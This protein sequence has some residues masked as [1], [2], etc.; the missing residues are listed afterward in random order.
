MR[1]KEFYSKVKDNN[2]EVVVFIRYGNFYRCYYNDAYIVS[3][4]FDYKLSEK[5]STG[6]PIKSIDKV[7]SILRNN[8]IS[9]IVIND[10]NNVINYICINNKYNSFLDLS[11]KN[12]TLNETLFSI[13]KE[14]KELLTKNINN[15]N[16]II[17][18]IRSI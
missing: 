11:K 10:I 3:Y 18:F 1:L 16:I 15:Y 4:L 2:E 8:N 13:N 5:N 17:N 9:C 7:I 6:F 12:Y 14:V